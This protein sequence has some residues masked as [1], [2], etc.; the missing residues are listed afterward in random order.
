M[1]RFRNS[2]RRNI[3]Y[4]HFKS[5]GSKKIFTHTSDI[6]HVVPHTQSVSTGFIYPILYFTKFHQ[7]TCI[8]KNKLRKKSEKKAELEDLCTELN[9]YVEVEIIEGKQDIY[10][11]IIAVE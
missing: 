10:S 6:S 11:Y 4:C 9:S 7:K 5:C 8:S 2:K 1:N 3:I